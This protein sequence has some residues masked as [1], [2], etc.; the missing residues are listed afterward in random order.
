RSDCAGAAVAGRRS[1]RPAAG[2]P[3]R[4]A[5]AG[6]A[7]HATSP[8]GRPPIAVVGISAIAPGSCDAGSFWRNICDGADLISDVPETHW[9]IADYYDP[10][11]AAPDKTYCKRGAFLS[12]T[13]F[14]ALEF[15]IP[16]STIPATD[17]S[18]LLALIVARQ[19]L[20]DASGHFR[21]VDRDRISVILGV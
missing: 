21:Q 12:E 17:T 19:V 7:V 9:R 20:N 13:D 10:N 6:I 15:G 1:R 16:P 8:I 14:D 11:P 4:P 2:V 18:Q 5:P 3:L